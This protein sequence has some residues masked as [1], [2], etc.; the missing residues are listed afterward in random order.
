MS[1]DLPNIKTSQKDETSG[2]SN[3]IVD[4]IYVMAAFNI[5]VLETISKDESPKRKLVQIRSVFFNN[6]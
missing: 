2:F 4:R 3:L 1:C 6:F 5:Q